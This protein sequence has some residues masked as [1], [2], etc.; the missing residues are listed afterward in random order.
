MKPIIK[1]MKR[2]SL[3]LFLLLFTLQTPSLA[4]NINDLEIDGISIGDSLL[5]Y[6]S[7]SEIKKQLS[8]TTSSYKRKRINS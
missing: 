1:L 5:D 6:Y 7:V 4:D 8:K 3:Y 2:L